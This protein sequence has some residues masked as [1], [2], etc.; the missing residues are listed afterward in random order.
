PSR[1][2]SDKSLNNTMLEP[3]DNMVFKPDDNMVFKPDY[4]TMLEPKDDT[5]LEPEDDTMLEPEAGN[6]DESKS[7]GMNRYENSLQSFISQTSS[8]FLVK[9][10]KVKR[11]GGSSVKEFYEMK[12][13]N[14]L[15]YQICHHKT[16]TSKIKY[17][18]DGS[19]SNLW[20]HLRNKHHISQAMIEGDQPFS[21]IQLR[22]FKRIIE[23]LDVQVNILGN[24][25]LKEIL[26]NSENKVL[27]NLHEYAQ[28]SSEVSYI[29]FTT[30]MWMSNNGDLYIGL[31]L[32]WIND[33][34]FQLKCIT[35]RGTIDNLAI[36]DAL[37]GC[38]E[39][40]NLIKK[41]KNVVSHFSRSPKQKQFFLEAQ[42]EMEDWNNFL[43]VVCDV[44]MRWNSIFYLLKQLTILK[45]A[46]YK[47]KSFLVEINDNISLRSY[48]EKELSSCQWEKIT[49]LVKLLYLYKIISKKLSDSQ[50]PTLSQAWF[51]INFIKIKLNCAITNDKPT[52]PIRL[53]VFFDLRTKNMQIFS[54]DERHSTISEARIEY[55]E[56]ATNYYESNNLSDAAP[57]N[58]NS[59]DIFSSSVAQE[60]SSQNDNNIANHEFNSYLLLPRVQSKTDI[61][62]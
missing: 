59:E 31:T 32:Y 57:S 6:L 23:G 28:D 39:I 62:Q 18:K 53:A 21:I 29:S 9:R 42:M 27:Q 3:E 41:Y 37:K 38:P 7:D 17:L 8:K 14:N 50:Y 60:Y 44:S 49:E 20:C 61:L 58:I 11:L 15:E 22:S 25:R 24:D 1:E 26:I 52:K 56:L 2:M 55:L 51:A 47:Y 48:E 10:K 33:N 13:I 40:T 30:D 16:C 46:M 5:M 34:S 54:E 4:D 19:T 35:T 12:L 45:P 43:F 36:N